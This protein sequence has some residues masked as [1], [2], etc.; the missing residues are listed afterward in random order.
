MFKWSKWSDKSTLTQI[1]GGKGI[2][3]WACYQ[4]AV[5]SVFK[6]HMCIVPL[7][8]H[9]LTLPEAGLVSA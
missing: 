8:T 1:I 7:R 4:Q 9:N 6:H 2:H 5:A 3:I